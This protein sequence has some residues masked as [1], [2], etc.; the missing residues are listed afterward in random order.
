M[1][2]TIDSKYPEGLKKYAEVLEDQHCREQNIDLAIDFYKRTLNLIHGD[3]NKNDIATRMERLY[4]KMGRDH[5]I[6]DIQQYLNQDRLSG[7]ISDDEDNDDDG[8]L[9]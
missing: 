1:L 2:A 3:A 5:E 6:R 7:Q 9:F 4:K 8:S